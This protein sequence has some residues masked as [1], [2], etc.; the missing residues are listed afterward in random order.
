MTFAIGQ[1]VIVS[2]PMT[3]MARHRGTILRKAKYGWR[4][5]F[6]AWGMACTETL[7]ETALELVP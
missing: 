3:P 2:P 6:D 4:V 1:S 7:P 5:R